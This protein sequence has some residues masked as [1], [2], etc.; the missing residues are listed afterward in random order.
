MMLYELELICIDLRWSGYLHQLV[1]VPRCFRQIVSD[2]TRQ[3]LQQRGPRS[4]WSRRFASSLEP[5]AAVGRVESSRLFSD[6]SS[7]VAKSSW[8]QVAELEEGR[9]QL[10]PR[11]EKWLKVFLFSTCI[12]YL[13]LLEVARVKICIDL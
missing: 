5:L 3:V 12:Y 1:V 9:L 8:C 2:K 13:C 10:V 4:R 11:R 7:S 6:P